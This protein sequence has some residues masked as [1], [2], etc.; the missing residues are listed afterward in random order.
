M[1]EEKSVDE[2]QA[3]LSGGFVTRILKEDSSN[4]FFSYANATVFEK[5]LRISIH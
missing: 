5:N 2:I 4:N 3:A 1:S